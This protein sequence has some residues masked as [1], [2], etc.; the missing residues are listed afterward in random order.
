MFIEIATIITDEDG[1]P[2]KEGKCLLNINAI[3][4]IIPKEGLIL[5]SDDKWAI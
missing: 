2:T 3:K 5:D 1:A 4:T